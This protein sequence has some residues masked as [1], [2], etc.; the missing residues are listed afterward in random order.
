MKGKRRAG[1]WK[2][3]YNDHEE[4]FK[5]PEGFIFLEYPYNK[6]G[7]LPQKASNSPSRIMDSRNKSVFL[8]NYQ[9]LEERDGEKISATTSEI[10]TNRERTGAALDI[11]T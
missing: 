7:V 1:N 3:F 4:Q 10:Q 2:D 9:L 11:I 8:Q 6:S 5:E